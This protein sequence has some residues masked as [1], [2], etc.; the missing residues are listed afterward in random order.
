MEMALLYV[1]SC[2]VV[3]GPASRLGWEVSEMQRRSLVDE[4]ETEVRI[5]TVVRRFLQAELQHAGQKQAVPE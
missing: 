4:R 1:G 2:P 3:M 5:P